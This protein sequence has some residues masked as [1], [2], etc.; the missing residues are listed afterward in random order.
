[1]TM[2]QRLQTV[3][4][5]PRTENDA[6][7]ETAILTTEPAELQPG[8]IYGWL[9]PNGHVT[10][11]DL[12]GDEYLEQPRRKTGTITVRDRS[13]FVEYWNKHANLDAAEVYANIDADVILAVLDAHT[14]SA[15]GWGRHRLVYRLH[16]SRAWNTWAEHDGRLMS[17]T[18]FAELLEAN[19]P[20]IAEPDGA[21]LLELAQTFTAHT[22]VS[23]KSGALLANGA[24]ELIYSEEV[25]ASGGRGGKKIVIPKQI[26]L[27]IP[28][29]EESLPST[30]TA[31]FRYR[32]NNGDLRLG[33]V[34]DQAA[35]HRK[36]VP[37]DRTGRKSAPRL[38]RLDD[39]IM[40][41]RTRGLSVVAAAAA[42]GV[43]ARTGQ[44]YQAEL[45]A[46]GRL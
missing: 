46:T 8:K 40:V 5:V 39:F 15:A 1:M 3:P 24:R 18:E 31:R 4:D 33:Y 27:V 30:V 26:T 23:F 32:I 2:S 17:Q 44:R 10:Q 34:L 42:V 38:A 28:V 41:R 25:E 37:P 29:Y 21:E 11:I 7:I 20:H 13:S 12:T 35:E 19:L 45:K 43:S 16:R 14:S 22:A 6:I 9:G 36:P